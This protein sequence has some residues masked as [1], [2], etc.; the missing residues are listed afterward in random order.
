MRIE[1]TWYIV[2]CPELVMDTGTNEPSDPD[3]NVST[4]NQHMN[5]RDVYGFADLLKRSCRE[6]CSDCVHVL[7]VSMT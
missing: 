1:Y 4:M 7:I 2:P 5:R 3:R 6:A